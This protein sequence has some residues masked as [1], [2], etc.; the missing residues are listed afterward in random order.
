MCSGKAYLKSILE[1]VLK[2]LPSCSTKLHRS[3]AVD[4][5]SMRISLVKSKDFLER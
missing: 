4:S 5:F 1:G 2:A 3:E